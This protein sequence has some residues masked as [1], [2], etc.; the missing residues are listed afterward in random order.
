M[1][2]GGSPAWVTFEGRN[3]VGKTSLA[4][5]AADRLGGRCHRVAE[6]T[7]LPDTTLPGQVLHALRTH[8]DAFL[9]TGAPHT[10]TQLLMALQTHRYETH[11][12][13][14]PGHVVVEDR[15]P[16]SVAVYQAA[17]LHPDDT[18][19]ALGTAAAILETSARWR[20]APDATIVLR[21]D[22]QR[23]A[24]RYTARLGRT[25]TDDEK[26]IMTV[27]AT[28]YDQLAEDIPRVHVV[29]RRTAT[30]AGV[31]DEIVDICLDAALTSTGSMT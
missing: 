6:L 21:D 31:L 30:D 25:L 17:V 22:P 23:C 13:L 10:E 26:A 20:P 24:Q 11:P 7:D 29:D 15:G 14:P 5:A 19:A 18:D 27:A 8:G 1:T 9:R 2:T 12:P 28:L 4:T 16:L 3:G